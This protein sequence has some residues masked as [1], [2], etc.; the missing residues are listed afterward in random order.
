MS[1]S[2]FNKKDQIS[3][4]ET[5]QP[6][7]PLKFVGP[8]VGDIFGYYL[9]FWGGF[10]VYARTLGKRMG[11]TV[12]ALNVGYPAVG[13]FDAT[14][15]EIFFRYRPAK[16]FGFVGNFSYAVPTI[17]TNVIQKGETAQQ[18]RDIFLFLLPRSSGDPSFLEGMQ[19]MR[20]ELQEWTKLD[21]TSLQKTSL[22]DVVNRALVAFVSGAMLGDTLCYDLLAAVWPSP[23][24]MP[25]F[26]ALPMRLLPAYYKMRSSLSSLREMM[27]SSP[28]W[29]KISKKAAEVGINSDQLTN[30]LLTAVGINS[31]GM[32]SSFLNLLLLLPQIP[33][34]GKE[35]LVNEALLNSFCWE[36][37]RFTG[38][39][40]GMELE[41]QT[42]IS[43]SSGEH[44]RLKKGSLLFTH[45]GY[46]AKDPAIYADPD[47]F[48]LDRFLTLPPRDMEVPKD[49]MEPLPMLP[50][51]CPLGHIDRE[52]DFRQAH[53]CPAMHLS[54]PLLKEIVTMLIRDFSWDLDQRSKKEVAALLVPSSS[55]LHVSFLP[56]HLRGGVRADDHVIATSKK[57]FFTHFKNSSSV[58]GDDAT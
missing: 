33:N 48:K 26:P 23:M 15:A 24:M 39:A 30:N 42:T 34:G 56:S 2:A 19:F 53:R 45:T 8:Y 5:D 9:N 6:L 21:E 18:T 52:D 46:P 57:P 31:Q 25:Q 43:S 37:I 4:Y 7:C 12:F 16:S 11:S 29:P 13:C 20:Q 41:E 35:L 54:H 58:V 55:Y 10:N 3:P 17:T 40:L 50:F 36:L 32:K 49:N 44:Y 1:S 27:H 47:I 51:A 38:V 28:N 22:D 14:S